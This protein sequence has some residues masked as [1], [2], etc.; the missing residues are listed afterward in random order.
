MAPLDL[1]G[2]RAIVTGAS[3]G[4]GRATAAALAA[5]GVPWRAARGASSGSRPR[6]RSSST[7]PTPRAASGF[8][9][10]AVEQL[11][12]LD[13]LVNNAGRALGRA[14]FDESSDEDE[15]WVLRHQRRRARCG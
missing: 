13:I 9:A 7:S 8:V 10:E 12:G 1:T 4:I 6:S 15:A 11:G 3:S 2:K 5:A 14:P